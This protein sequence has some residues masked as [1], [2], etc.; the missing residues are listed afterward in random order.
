MLGFVD[1][2]PEYDNLFIVILQ[3][4]WKLLY[5]Q[6]KLRIVLFGLLGGNH[7]SIMRCKYVTLTGLA[8]IFYGNCVF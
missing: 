2:Q 5:S 8:T 3:G 4:Q 7:V 1:S 6:G